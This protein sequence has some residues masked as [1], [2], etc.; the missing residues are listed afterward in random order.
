MIEEINKLKLPLG[1]WQEFAKGL[2]LQENIVVENIQIT[3]PDSNTAAIAIPGVASFNLSFM[4]GCKAILISHGTIIQPSYRNR[5]LSYVLQTIKNRIA[6]DLVVAALIATVRVDNTPE[7]KVISKSDWKKLIKI[8]N[9]RSGNEID[10]II[11][12]FNSIVDLK[13]S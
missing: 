12:Q 3:Y 13:S 10:L 6:K 5:K 7:Q 1:K 9:V 2:F 8:K 4:Y 11:K